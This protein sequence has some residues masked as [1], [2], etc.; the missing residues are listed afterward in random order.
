MPHT[1]Q[2][3]L[4]G[5]SIALSAFPAGATLDPLTS[6]PRDVEASVGQLDHVYLY[7]LDG[8][9]QVVAR[10]LAQRRGAVEAAGR[11]VAAQVDDHVMRD[12]RRT[13]FRTDPSRARE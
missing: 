3:A 4:L 7:D 1:G 10:T 2:L 8:L 12:R 5:G 13:Q 9:Q 6:T 11:I